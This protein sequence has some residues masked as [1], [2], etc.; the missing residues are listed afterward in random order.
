MKIVQ[1]N[2]TCGTGSIGKI[3]LEVSKHLTKKGIEN[4]ILYSFGHSDYPLA[5]NYCN[6]HIRKLQ[7]LYEKVSGMYGFGARFTTGRLL[8]QLEEINPDIVHIHNIHSHDCDVEMLFNYLNRHHIRVYWTFHDCWAFTGYCPYFDMA[9]CNKWKTGCDKCKIFRQF[10]LIFDRSQILYDK[11]KK[12]LLNADLTIIT[13][14]QWL[15]KLVKA[16]FLKDKDVRVINNGIDLSEFKPTQSNIRQRL[17]CKDKF[18]V[19]GVANVWET[20]KGLDVF[21]KLANDLGDSYQIILVGTS[22]EIDK[23][24]PQNIVSIH[25]TENQKQLAELYTASD[26]F[27]IPTL[28]DNFPTVNIEAL[29][30]GTP[31]L[32]YDTGGSAEIIEKTCGIAVPKG[33]YQALKDAICCISKYNPYDSR[34]CVERASLFRNTDKY[35]EYLNLYENIKKTDKS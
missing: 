19:L 10:S 6:E 32:T 33:N 9:E 2:A 24:L 23:I 20:R 15:S 4:Y 30:C 7:S 18:V 16:S 1:I 3:C 26:L 22:K 34:S 31:V 21:I 5:I 13:P 11:K 28:E 14:S 29:A 12:A 27:V 8:K 17:K 35:N 25:K